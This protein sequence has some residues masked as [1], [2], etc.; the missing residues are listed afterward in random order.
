MKLFSSLIQPAYAQTSIN[1][2]SPEG[3]PTDL[4]AIISGLVNAAIVIGAL[5]AFMY[6]VLGGFQWITAGGDKAKTEEA[7][8]KITNAI[9]GLVIIVAAWAI[10][11]V[12]T[13]FLGIGGLENL[14]IP[15]IG[16][17]VG[18]GSSAQGGGNTIQQ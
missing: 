18:S 13:N 9:I 17:T 14:T 6:L 4:G 7:Q 12:V 10:I 1:L 8:K 5:A 16:G 2:T 11:N 3:A 15:A